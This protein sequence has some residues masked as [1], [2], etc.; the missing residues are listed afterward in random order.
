LGGGAAS[1]FAFKDIYWDDTRLIFQSD[2]VT[3]A[4][5]IDK[6]NNVCTDIAGKIKIYCFDGNSTSQTNI[7]NYGLASTVN[8]YDVMP[9]WT[10]SHMMSDLVFAV[11]R[12][13]YNATAGVKGLGK[14]KFKINN[15]MTQPGDCMYDYMTNTR[16][17]AGIDPTEIYAS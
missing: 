13:D 15:S 16:Y 7:T 6:S 17:G 10:S 5:Y 3:V 8:A 11:I 9:N 12:V 1:T 4:G 14:V 2:G